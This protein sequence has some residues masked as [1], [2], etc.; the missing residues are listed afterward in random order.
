VRLLIALL[1][2]LLLTLQAWAR[3]SDGGPVTFKDFTL[4]VGDRIDIG[5]YRAE[6]IEIQSVRDGL[7]VMRVSKIRGALSEQRAFL[8]NRA[9]NFDGS[10]EDKGIT[11]TVIDVLD[12][13]SAKVRV[14]YKEVLGTARKRTAERPPI[15]K[16]VPQLEIQKSFD[17]N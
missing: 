11:I 15:P 10:A 16:D 12:E 7:A 5:N 9:N 14:E 17:K 3:E 1:I 2:L 6:L 8:Q 4:N 13:Q